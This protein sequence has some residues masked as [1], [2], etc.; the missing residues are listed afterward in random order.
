MKPITKEM[1]HI[2]K[3]LSGLDWMNYKIVRTQMTFHHIIKK[4]DG[5]LEV[6]ENGAL[7][8]SNPHQ[9]LHTIEYTDHDT[10]VALNKIFSFINKQ[11]HEPTMEQRQ[12]IEYLLKS[13][14]SEHKKD[15]TSKGKILI[16][17]CYLKRW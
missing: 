7:L 6:I 17:P 8:M 2:Y 11:G 15:K 1:L 12:I 5:G 10:Y 13:F 3:P 4:C 9:Y 14:E 16:K